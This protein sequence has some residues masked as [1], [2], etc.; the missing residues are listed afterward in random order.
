MGPAP[1]C[2]CEIGIIPDLLINPTV[3]LMP[4]SPF[5]DEGHTIEPSVS[6]PIEAA[7]KLAEVD[8]PEPELDPHGFLSSA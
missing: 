2:V 5:A 7:H 3:G 1:S 4:T 6:D 8:A